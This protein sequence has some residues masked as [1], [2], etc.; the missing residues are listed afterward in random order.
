[1]QTNRI[2]LTLGIFICLNVA[3]YFLFAQKSVQKGMGA[4]WSI[5]SVQT[6]NVIQ[7]GAVIQ[8]NVNAGNPTMLDYSYYDKEKM[9]EQY[10]K[11]AA[12]GIKQFSV[13]QHEYSYSYYQRYTLVLGFLIA[14]I[15]AT[16]ISFVRRVWYMIQGAIVYSMFFLFYL[17]LVFWRHGSQK[18]VLLYDPSGFEFWYR[19]EIAFGALG[20]LLMLSLIIYGLMVFNKRQSR[21]IQNYFFG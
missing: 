14:L 1:M 8:G 3:F 9:E 11:A 20:F 5:L 7:S 4:I 18:P 12:Q 16:P 10:A 13:D 17:V 15:L 6:I 2:F 19:L 21:I